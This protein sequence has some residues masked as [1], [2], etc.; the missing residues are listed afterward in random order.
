MN[1][2]VWTQRGRDLGFILQVLGGTAIV[3]GSILAVTALAGAL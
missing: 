3:Y 1:G 2:I